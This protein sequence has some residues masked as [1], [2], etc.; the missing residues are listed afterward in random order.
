MAA[1]AQKYG[2]IVTDQTHWAIG[3]LIQSPSPTAS[4][5]FYSNGRPG[6]AGPFQGKWPNQLLSYFPWSA[7]QVL[8]M[9]VTHG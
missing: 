2:M 3:F 7:V 6:L 1:A 8:K 9:K 4:N 5:M